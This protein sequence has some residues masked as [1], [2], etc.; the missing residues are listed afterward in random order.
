M[1]KVYKFLAV[2][3]V[4]SILILSA[5]APMGSPGGKTGSPGDEGATCIECHPGNDVQEAEGWITSDIPD[6]GYIPGETYTITLTGT[7]PDITKMGFELTAENEAGKVGGLAISD[8]DRTHFTNGE[9][10]VTHTLAGNVPDGNTNSICFLSCAGSNLCSK[11]G[12]CIFQQ[13][14]LSSNIGSPEY[15]SSNTSKS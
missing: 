5:W 8:A 11:K 3:I 10:A 15:G 4:P 6:L 13:G 12:V 2:L 14:I 9:N 7:H 1:K